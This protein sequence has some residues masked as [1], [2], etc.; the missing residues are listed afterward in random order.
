M[1]EERPDE[2]EDSARLQALTDNT[3][4]GIF[5]Y[6]IDV[7]NKREIFEKRWIWELLQNALDATPK[8]KRIDVRIVRDGNS[9]IFSH[10]GR[11][12]RSEEVAHLIYHGST[13]KESYIGKFGTG[14]LV[15]HLLS[16]RVNVSGIRDDGNSF[17]FLLDRSGK[18]ADE[19]KVLME[20]TWNQYKQSLQDSMQ[21]QA[22]C[23][24]Y[25]YTI[26][27]ASEATATQGIEILR[28]IAP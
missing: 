1:D 16:K 25:Q 26:D 19:I 28:R 17:R 2:R 11:P 10:D 15:T 8:D 21:K 12:F 20:R 24:E 3:A 13:K 4:Q 18:T 7:E 5:N 14:F 9:L 22:W 27:G 6:L 23:A